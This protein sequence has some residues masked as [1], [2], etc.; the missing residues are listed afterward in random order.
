MF[1]SSRVPF[2]SIRCIGGVNMLMAKRRP[3]GYEVGYTATI[4]MMNQDRLSRGVLTIIRGAPA[5]VSSTSADIYELPLISDRW[6]PKNYPKLQFFKTF[7]LL[8][9]DAKP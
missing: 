3:G 2:L 1:P 7:R 4:R 9:S 8:A 6:P 5:F